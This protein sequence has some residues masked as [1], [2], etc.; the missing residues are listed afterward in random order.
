MRRVESILQL[1]NINLPV[2]D[3]STVSRRL[4]RLK[5]ELPVKKNNCP[6]HLVVDSTQ[7]TCPHVVK[8]YGEG[9]WK[10]RQ[11]GISQR[12]SAYAQRGYRPIVP[13]GLE[14]LRS[15]AARRLESFAF[16]WRKLHLGIDEATGE[17]VSA[18]ATT[19]DYHDSQVLE[20]ILDG[21][22][23]N[24]QQVSTDGAYD[25]QRCYEAI[26]QRQAKAIIPPRKNAKIKQH[27]NCQK[28]P[29]PRDENLRAIRRSAFAQSVARRDLGR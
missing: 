21:V 1:M 22:E 17:I 5:I 19:N 9:E 24:L 29:L 16:V 26:R 6:R 28:P 2:P 20:D 7:R 8:V 12:H 13:S 10:T 23:D 11:H 18:V 15:R 4:G 25:T 27:G 3:H 14:S